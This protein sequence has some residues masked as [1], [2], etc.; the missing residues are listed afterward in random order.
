MNGKGM[1]KGISLKNIP[2]PFI[3]LP[4]FPWQSSLCPPAM[5]EATAQKKF[6]C[7]ACGAAAEWNPPSNRC[8]RM[9]THK[10]TLWE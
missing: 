7:P 4:L 2:L 8:L 6:S 1:T 5:S 9:R 10:F 3:P